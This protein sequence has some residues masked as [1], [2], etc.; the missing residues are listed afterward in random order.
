MLTFC[1]KELLISIDEF[2]MYKS[3]FAAEKEILKNAAPVICLGKNGRLI[4]PMSAKFCGETVKFT[5]PDN[6]YA[7]V[8]IVENGVSVS[9][10][11]TDI[12]DCD[13]VVF[14]PFDV[15]IGDTVGEVVGVAQ[16]GGVAFGV[17]ALNIKTLPGISYEYG[18]MMDFEHDIT[19]TGCG[20]AAVPIDGGARFCFHCRRR[21]RLEYRRVASVEK[22]LTLPLND[23]VDAEIVGAKIALFGT[24]QQNALNKIGEIE[25]EQG[26]PHPLFEGEWNKTSRKTMK[27]YIIS[28]FSADDADLMLEKAKKAGIDRVYHEGPFVNWGHFDLMPDCFPNGDADLKAF[29]KKMH[30]NGIKVGVHTLTNFTTTND[31]YV[32]P[33]PSGHLLKIGALELTDDIGENQDVIEIKNSEMFSQ[34]L[35]LNAMHIGDELITYSAAEP[36]G[37]TVTLTGCERGAFGTELSAHMKSEPLWLLWDY[38]YKTLFPDIELQDE[39]CGRLVELFNSTG[40]DQ[41]SFDG[42][43]GCCYTGHDEYAPVRFVDRCHR[44]WDSVRSADSVISDAS[45]LHHYSWHMHSYMNW[46][47]PWGE[48]MRTGQTEGR[49]KNQDFFRRNLF[50]RMFGWMLIRLADRKFEATTPEEF[51]WALSMSA[52]FDCG[53]AVSVSTKTL[54]NHGMIDTI[55]NSVKMWDK[56][57]IDGAFPESLRG[58]LRD[59]KT[60]WHMEEKDGRHL[61]YPLDISKP[62]VCDLAEQQP[63]QP[64]GS[65]WSVEHKYSGKFGMR[66]RVEGDGEIRNPMIKT[67]AGTVKFPCTV[68]DGQYLIFNLPGIKNEAAVTDKNFN[69][70]EEITPI[71]VAVFNEK[72]GAVSFSCDHDRD[73]TPEITIRFFTQ[74]KAIELEENNND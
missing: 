53:Y 31:P 69:V 12:S 18:S 52:G 28:G 57:R 17:Q 73:D 7:D 30:E 35:T 62:Y 32:T 56:L 36:H 47:E 50:P 43:E 51:E 74:G 24:E 21:D 2:G 71:G 19:V 33:V 67:A 11:I 60:E 72:S 13:A 15:N 46:G 3:I 63:G 61:L 70:I 9:L 44:G 59:V 34:P 4:K 58:Q 42:L 14:G 16:G 48:A 37:E 54:K 29:I 68:A 40:I 10:E 22:S 41:I 5:F 65:D 1:T 6:G 49:I 64:G 26:L 45:N 27:S 8:K 20:N 55:L 39:F 38:P 25:L 23:D 66:L